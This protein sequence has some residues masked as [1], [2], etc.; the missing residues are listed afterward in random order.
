[1]LHPASWLLRRA[2][3]VIT[4]L[5]LGL[6]AA[7]A[8]LPLAPV[9]WL[10]DL[11]THFE[12]HYVVLSGLLLAL[13]VW[14]RHGRTALLALGLLALHTGIASFPYASEPARAAAPTRF[15]SIAQYNVL[16]KNPEHDLTAA[17]VR[18]TDPDVICLQEISQGWQDDLLSALP[19]FSLVASEPRGDNYGIAML[20]RPGREVGLRDGRL[21]R[22]LEGTP[23]PLAVVHASLSVEGR[24]VQ[25]LTLHA[26]PPFSPTHDRKRAELLRAVAAWVRVQTS[27]VIVTGDFNASPWSTPFKRFLA[28]TGLR[29][30]QARSGPHATWMPFWGVLGG[31][32]IDHVLHSPTLQTVHYAVGPDTGSDH[33]GVH[34]RLGLSSR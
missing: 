15:V 7:T 32:V 1:M 29:N 9:Y 21:L 28:H 10:F 19:E 8:A 20:H 31:L 3:K 14:R 33:R 6:L 17:Y 25:L 4:I 18:G 22:S 13:A 12:V 30:S 24:P 11:F 16:T 23:L 2:D 27:P 26:H 5:T 34:V